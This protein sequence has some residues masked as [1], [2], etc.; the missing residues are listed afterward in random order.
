MFCP[1]E[2]G[3]NLMSKLAVKIVRIEFNYAIYL[4]VARK[5]TDFFPDI[6]VFG[7]IWTNSAGCRVD[8]ALSQYRYTCTFTLPSGFP[9][10]VALVIPLL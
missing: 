9:G 6:F 8:L 3:L 7:V 4:H 10:D 1:F 2:A 5:V